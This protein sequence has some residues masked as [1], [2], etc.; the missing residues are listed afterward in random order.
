L[1]C[2]CDVVLD[3]HN[4]SRRCSARFHARSS[5]MRC[6]DRLSNAPSRSS[7]GVF[8][9]TLPP[10]SFVN[11]SNGIYTMV[12]QNPPRCDIP[13]KLCV[14]YSRSQLRQAPDLIP[15]PLINQLKAG[16]R[17]VIPVGLP[18]A[19]QLLVADKDVNGR[20]RT[21]EIMRVLFSLLEGPNEPSFRAS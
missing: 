16:G 3:E 21:K 17:M 19:Q 15:P 20:V 9:S 4:I 11:A 14:R 8:R 1:G 10:S 13:N 2:V 5:S 12:C 7:Y 18:D 6:R